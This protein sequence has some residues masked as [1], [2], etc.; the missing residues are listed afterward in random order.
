MAVAQPDAGPK[1]RVGISYR[2]GW[3]VKTTFSGLGGMAPQSNPGP[4][5]GAANREYDDGY[6]LVDST[7]SGM[8]LTWNWG[9]DNP[10]QV[11]GDTLSMRS[12]RGLADGSASEEDFQHGFEVTYARELGTIR[13]ARW[14]V[15][16][17][18]NFLYVGAKSGRAVPFTVVATVDNYDL[19]G[20]D[21]FTPPGSQTPNQGTFV[22]PG[23]LIPDAPSSRREESTPGGALAT[24]K[25]ELDANVF[26]LRIGPYIDFPLSA[27]WMLT[28]NAG[29]ALAA[30]KSDFKFNETVSTP[31][32]QA[33]SR[34]DSASDSELLPG[35][36]AG[37]NISFQATSATRVFAGAEYQH[38]GDFTQDAGGKRA[39]LDLGKTVFVKVG[40]SFSF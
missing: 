36:Y 28:L 25:R 17:A 35:G 8:D 15:E 33:V 21:P 37:A 34:R 11:S 10:E 7:N 39:R 14:G 22:G 13:K 20:I 19:G 2:P 30:V 40:V 31:D 1:N 3:N 29:F 5:T 6:V 4:T 24:G 23:P 9:F 26:G 16:G 32:L 27:K 18:F 38:V 12:A